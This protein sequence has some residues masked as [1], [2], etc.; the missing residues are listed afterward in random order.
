MY[1]TYDYAPGIEINTALG[2]C[3]QPESE[4]WQLSID[5]RRRI[6]EGALKFL[7]DA[8]D[9]ETIEYHRSYCNSAKLIDAIARI[10]QNQLATDVEMD[11]AYA[12]SES[13][14]TAIRRAERRRSP[15]DD[16]RQTVMKKYENKCAYCG[17]PATVI[18]HVIPYVQGG[19]TTIE[20]LASACQP[21]N[22]KKR[23]RTPEQAGMVL[24]GENE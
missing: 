9:I 16:I 21:C 19:K 12:I 23:G 22:S 4:Y 8:R 10:E 1:T 5:D 14:Q 17:A 11:K 24:R 20:N 15:P 18:D 7:Q 3:I 13:I 2:V 6:D